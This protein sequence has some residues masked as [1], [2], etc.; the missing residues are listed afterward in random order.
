MKKYLAIILSILL[1]LSLTACKN[2]E[3]TNQDALITAYKN[4]M[5][6][7]VESGDNTTA[8]KVLE[9]GISITNSNEL[10]KMLNELKGKDSTESP[11][12]NQATTSADN[13]NGDENS[14]IIIP[15]TKTI[16][17]KDYIGSWATTD[18]MFSNGGFS[19]DIDM[20]KGIG[21]LK[22]ISFNTF[23]AK[24]HWQ[25]GPSIELIIEKSELTNPKIETSFTDNFDNEGFITI[26]FLDDSIIATITEVDSD[27]YYSEGTYT[28]TNIY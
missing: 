27:K 15:P 25:D 12:D 10:K 6:E 21:G 11:K 18:D 7:F 4:K 24:P 26:E 22:Y 13:S 8:I 3:K 23:Y 28:M 2:N 20:H 14:E 19:I 17:I 9:E 16:N 1:I 5:T